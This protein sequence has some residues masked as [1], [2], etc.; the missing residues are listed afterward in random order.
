MSYTANK[1][2][3]F[4]TKGQKQPSKE[5]SS[6]SPQQTSQLPA[7]E[8]VK[9][10]T[11]GVVLTQGDNSK[12]F[13]ISA[14]AKQRK[15]N[16]AH[17]FYL[18]GEENLK[19]SFFQWQP[20]HLSA[21]SNFERASELFRAAQQ[22]KRALKA[23]IMSADEYEKCNTLSSSALNKA[24]AADLAKEIGDQAHSVE[25]LFQSAETWGINGDL[26][27]YGETLEKAAKEVV[28][29]RI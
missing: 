20:D 23:M 7:P 25:L 6:A 22:P 16:E 17:E 21:A 8:P 13:S 24:K 2:S 28:S 4:A 18:K 9:S 5:S 27:K 12:P 1:Q 15:L 10:K 3:L 11:A 14:E 26:Q 19:T 29:L